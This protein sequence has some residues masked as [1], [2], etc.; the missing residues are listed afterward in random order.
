MEI[1]VKEMGKK[2]GKDVVLK[3]METDRG[4][5]RYEMEDGCNNNNNNNTNRTK[6]LT[7]KRSRL[8]LAQSMALLQDNSL[9]TRPRVRAGHHLGCRARGGI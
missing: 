8:R 3:V 9:R 4:E 6:K 5:S 2:W 7:S 1:I